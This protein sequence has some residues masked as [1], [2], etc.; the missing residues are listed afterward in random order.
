M[1]NFTYCLF[2]L[3]YTRQTKGII[4]KYIRSNHSNPKLNTLGGTF[5]YFFKNT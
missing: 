3:L 4:N 1:L 5:L 2:L